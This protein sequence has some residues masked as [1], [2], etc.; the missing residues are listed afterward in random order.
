MAS[1]TSFYSLKATLYDVVNIITTKARSNESWAGFS[2]DQ[3]VSRKA[4]SWFSISTKW[5]KQSVL[6]HLHL[7]MRSKRSSLSRLAPFVDCL[8]RKRHK[9]ITYNNV[10]TFFVANL[11]GKKHYSKPTLTYNQ[12]TS[13]GFVVLIATFSE[14]CCNLVASNEVQSSCEKNSYSNTEL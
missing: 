6:W 13:L 4:M 9:L 14:H 1:Q 12:V 2:I 8:P 3:N 5:L 11:W 10:F 7:S